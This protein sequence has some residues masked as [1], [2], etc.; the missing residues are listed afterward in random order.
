MAKS[1]N[2]LVELARFIFSMLV[3]GYH[4]QMTWGGAGAHFFA[5]G[6]LA[7]EFFFLISGFFMARSIEKTVDLDVQN[8]TSQ[9][10]RFIW[11]KIKGILPVHIVAMILMIFVVVLTRRDEA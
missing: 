5:G 1:R 10:K 8:I 3:V 2:N 6:A 7:V 4:V 9:T 11:S